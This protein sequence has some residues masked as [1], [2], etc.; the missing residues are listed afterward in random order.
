MEV[1]KTKRANIEK[2][3]S[4]FKLIGLIITLSVVWSA[5]E[6]K[7]YDKVNVDIDQVSMLID[8]GDIILQTTRI[9]PPPPPPKPIS[10][11]E[12]IENTAKTDVDIIIDVETSTMEEI[13]NLK[14]PEAEEPE[15]VEKVFFIIVEEMPS[16]KGGDKARLEYLHNNMKYPE[17]AKEINAQGTVYVRFIVETD[18]SISNVYVARGIGS[19]CD[20]EALRVV[21][22]M[23]PWNPGKQRGIAVRT[24]LIM[25]IKYILKQY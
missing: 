23:P 1:K 15:Y 13:E 5:F 9:K 22:N 25:P 21:K 3:K 4:T 17:M 18:G 19:G 12:I 11:I 14:M 24:Q 6:Y 10:I 20:I 7:T 16:Y 8:D 2:G